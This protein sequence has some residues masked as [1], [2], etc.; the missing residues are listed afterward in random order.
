MQICKYLLNSVKTCKTS[1]YKTKHCLVWLENMV[2]YFSARVQESGFSRWAIF[3]VRSIGLV[4]SWS[5]LPITLHGA[6]RR[7]LL[8]HNE[9]TVGAGHKILCPNI[10][11]FYDSYVVYLLTH[12]VTRS[13][14]S[15]LRRLHVCFYRC[16][17]EL[18]CSMGV[19]SYVFKGLR[20]G[21]YRITKPTV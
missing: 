21:E 12:V 15:V 16:F 7:L 17:N 3:W 13:R 11:I 20:L 14:L 10:M 5:V 9:T 1:S 4:T 19:W 8:P 2:G 18:V 6:C